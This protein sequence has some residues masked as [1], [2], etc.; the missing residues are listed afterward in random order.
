M[1]DLAH[2]CRSQC[3]HAC[4]GELQSDDVAHNEVDHTSLAARAHRHTSRVGRTRHVALAQL[5]EALGQLGRGAGEVKLQRGGEDSR[6]RLTKA[7]VAKLRN[8]H[9]AERGEVGS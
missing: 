9:G 3:G 6:I 1:M 4:L 7:V 2:V 5:V 8:Q